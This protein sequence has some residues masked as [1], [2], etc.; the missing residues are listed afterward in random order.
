[1]SGLSFGVGEHTASCDCGGGGC[2]TSSWISSTIG[3]VPSGW[4]G[5]AIDLGYSA[6]TVGAV[7]GTGLPVFSFDGP[8]VALRW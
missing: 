6:V 1:M 7:A 8:V 3:D 5:T 4:S 2:S